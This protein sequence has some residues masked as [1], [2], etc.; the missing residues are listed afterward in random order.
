MTR[1]CVYTAAYG[2]GEPLPVQEVRAES[3]V[4]FIAFVGDPAI[5]S[6]TWTIRHVPPLLPDDP[7]RSSRYV[8]MHPHLLLPEFDASLYIDGSILL[9]RRPEDIFQ[10]L[11][12]GI[13]DTMACFRHDQRRNIAEEAEAIAAWDLDDPAIVA[14]QLHAYALDGHTG[15]VPLIWAGF[16]LRFHNDKRVA[17]FMETWFSHVM[18]FSR[19]DQLAFPHVAEKTGFPMYVHDID[20][21][22]SERHR[23]VWDPDKP[24]TPWRPISVAAPPLPESGLSRRLLDVSARLDDLGPAAVVRRAAARDA[25]PWVAPGRLPAAT[26]A[27]RHLRGSLHDARGRLA[28]TAAELAAA[29][30]ALEAKDAELV[31]LKAEL[32]AVRRSTSWRLT[33]PIRRSLDALRRRK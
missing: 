27:L 14:E 2:Q 18:A 32:D 13:T 17:E 25:E 22:N 30:E 4:D 9:R 5:Q 6:E 20:T 28:R 23:L 16:L 7:A 24:R 21:E 3:D 31:R 11:L 15:S 8:K 12:F 19:R 10:S 26:V 1:C 29:R 33:S